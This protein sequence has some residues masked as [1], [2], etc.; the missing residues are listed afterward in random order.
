MGNRAEPKISSECGNFEA[1]VSSRKA[2]K[3][4]AKGEK[5]GDQGK[6]WG[7]EKEHLRVVFYPTLARGTGVTCVTANTAFRLSGRSVD[8]TP[9]EKLPPYFLRIWIPVRP[10][11]LLCLEYP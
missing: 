3:G 7:K 1:P 2:L 11:L 5:R 6:K 8:A 9:R 10:F 4:A